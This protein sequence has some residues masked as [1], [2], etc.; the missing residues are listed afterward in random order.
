MAAYRAYEVFIGIVNMS[1]HETIFKKL[2]KLGVVDLLKN[3]IGD[4]KSRSKPFMDLSF[5]CLSLNESV[6]QIALAHNYIQ[7]GDVC[8]DPDMEIR[9]NLKTGEAEALSF[10][11]AMPPIYDV[12]YP[13]PGMVNPKLKKSLNSFLSSW[14]GN[15]I[16]QGHKFTH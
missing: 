9:L 16:E 5:D 13:E 8:A 6:A 7:N 14:L 10:Q 15:C 3:N 2:D 11:Q 1:I 12:V 4:S